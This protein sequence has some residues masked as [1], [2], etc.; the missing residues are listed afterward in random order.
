MGFVFKDKRVYFDYGEDMKKDE[1][2]LLCVAVSILL[3]GIILG[4]I[5]FGYHLNEPIDLE[6]T[7]GLATVSIALL[8]VGTSIYVIYQ[9]DRHNRNSVMPKLNTFAYTP[10]KD[11]MFRYQLVNLGIGPAII[12]NI[13]Y[14]DGND[15]YGLTTKEEIISYLE[16]MGIAGKNAGYVIAR[17]GTIILHG[18]KLELINVDKKEFLENDLEEIIDIF[19]DTIKL[20]VV[21]TSI[22]DD[23]FKYDR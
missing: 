15:I 16:H 12:K 8:A 4:F 7:I 9:N 6:I 22:L 19:R 2:A 20:K 17:E 10:D 11:G 1:F 21:Y 5:L 3:F 18:E 23:E 14:I 13:N